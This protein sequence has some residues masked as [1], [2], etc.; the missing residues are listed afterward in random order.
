MVLFRDRNLG[1]TENTGYVGNRKTKDKLTTIKEKIKTGQG[2]TVLS[3]FD[4]IACGRVAL[5]RAGIPISAYLA[6]EIKK[7]A[8]KCAT[9]NNPDI[10]EIGDVTKIHYADGVLYTEHGNHTVG[11]VDLLIG[12]SPCQDFSAVG[13]RKGLNGQKSS[14]FFEYLRLLKEVHP[15]FFLLENVVTPVADNNYLDWLLGV[16]GILIDS[17]CVSMQRRKRLYWTDIPSVVPPKAII[18]DYT[19]CCAVVAQEESPERYVLTHT[20][21]HERSWN[22]GKNYTFPRTKFANITNMQKCGTLNRR[23]N[24]TPNEGLV[25]YN[26]WCRTLSQREIEIAQTLPIGYTK[27]LAYS[28]AHDVVGDGWTVDVIAHIFRHLLKEQDNDVS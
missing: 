15:C 26:G 18:S 21:T 6:S 7:I 12:G 10:I 23:A 2:L 17:A 3:L 20:K 5:K 8:I 27:M 24:R 9:E 22:S 13:S 25:E 1:F 11:E 14:L 16:S 19:N 28:Q 4:G